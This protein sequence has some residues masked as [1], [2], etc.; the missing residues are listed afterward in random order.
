MALDLGSLGLADSEIV[1][2]ASDGGAKCVIAHYGAHVLSWTDTTG[3]ELLYLS[4][5]A[6]F[7]PGKTALRGGIPICWPSFAGRKP[8]IGKHGFVR[9]ATDWRLKDASAAYAQFEYSTTFERCATDGSKTEVDYANPDSASVLFRVAF[10][11]QDDAL[12]IQW[13]VLNDHEEKPLPFSGCL[14]TYFRMDEAGLAGGKTPL[15]V[16]G[17]APYRHTREFGVESENNASD[18]Q[19]DGR[20][21]VERMF[22]EKQLLYTREKMFDVASFGPYPDDL[23]DVFASRG[24]RGPETQEYRTKSSPVR[25]EGVAGKPIAL[26]SSIGLQDTVVWNIGSAAPDKIPKDMAAGDEKRYV[27]VEPGLVECEAVAYPGKVWR[28]WHVIEIGG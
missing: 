28:G 7:A 8:E 4:E 3:A 17:F 6:S 11:L 21:E 27:C 26:Y 22:F 13:T 16:G 20:Q 15:S 18:V 9:T 1:T 10:L 12:G 5:K 19:V 2:L 24:Y 23:T 25:F 14:H